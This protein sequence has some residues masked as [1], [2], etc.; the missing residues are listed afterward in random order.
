MHCA[1]PRAGWSEGF[2]G[3]LAAGA[4][5]VRI[6]NDSPCAEGKALAEEFVVAKL[7]EIWVRT[8]LRNKKANLLKINN[9]HFVLQNQ[10]N[11]KIKH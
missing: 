4:S 10:K 8:D 3:F 11:K 6:V 9:I 1:E 2:V 5:T 7:K